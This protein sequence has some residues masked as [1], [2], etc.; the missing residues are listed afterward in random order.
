MATR[1]DTN[2]SRLAAQEGDAISIHCLAGPDTLAIQNDMI[3]AQTLSSGDPAGDAYTTTAP[4]TDVQNAAA[5]GHSCHHLLHNDGDDEQAG[6]DE[7][8]VTR[9]GT[10]VPKSIALRLYT[11]HFLSTWN[12]RL[13][14]FGA[15][16][17]LT[18][19]FPGTLLPVSVYSLVRNA[20]YIMFAQPLGNWINE[21]NRLNII[22]TSI[23]GQRVPVAAS[24]ALLLVLELKG[25]DLGYRKDDGIFAVIVLLAVMEKLASTLNSISVERDWVSG[26]YVLLGAD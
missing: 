14:E 20:G 26:A 4:M 24:C 16:L 10:S 1:T 23:V 2:M 12:S 3:N 17:F 5:G 13:F 9:L 25:S 21:G 11:S 22:R 6:D 15:A 7:P 18:S 8:N 19:V